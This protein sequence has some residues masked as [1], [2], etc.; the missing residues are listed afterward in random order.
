MSGFDLVLR[1]GSVFVDGHLKRVNIGVRDGRIAA[2]TDA[3]LDGTT[4]LDAT[5]R[6][7]LPGGIDGH[8]HI[9][10]TTTTGGTTAADFYDATVGA[11]FGGTTLV[12]PFAAQHRGQSLRTSVAAYRERAAGRA[13]V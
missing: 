6:L 3:P 4:I 10:Q 13:V 9:A 12:M 2:L 7:V 8:C 1:D 11:A 5:G